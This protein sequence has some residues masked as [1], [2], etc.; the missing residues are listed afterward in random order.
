MQRIIRDY[1]KQLYVYK[2]PKMNNLEEIDKLLEVHP[3]KTELGSSRKYE[4]ISY[5][6]WNWNCDLKISNNKSPGPD[7][8]TGEFYQRFR[9]ELIPLLL[10]LRKVAE[11]HS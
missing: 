5:K 3:P 4:Q 11:E 8:F 1:Y 6:Y 10:K 2:P 9:E 7:I